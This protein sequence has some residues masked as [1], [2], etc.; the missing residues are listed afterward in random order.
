MMPTRT[1]C[2]VFEL[3][4]D[5]RELLKVRPSPAKAVVLR[6][7]LRCFGK[8]MNQFTVT[9]TKKQKNLRFGGGLRRFLC[10]VGGVPAALF[11]FYFLMKRKEKN[12][13]PAALI[14]SSGQARG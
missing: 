12:Y 13:L 10:P 2:W 14:R 3:G 11:C 8:S 5:K 1:G 4:W 7:S 6:K 9:Y